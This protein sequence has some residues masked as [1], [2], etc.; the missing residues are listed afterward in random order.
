[1]ANFYIKWKGEI[2]GPFS[3]SEILEMLNTGKIGLLHEIREE[4]SESWQFLKDFDISKAENATQ[5]KS[6]ADMMYAAF[7]LG[8]ASFLHPIIYLF[9]ILFDGYIFFRARARKKTQPEWI[10]LAILITAVSGMAGI[11]F[12]KNI[13]PVLCGK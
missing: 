3:N 8:G 5:K 10:R 13:Y 9:A 6:D 4:N 12:Y 2:S 11:I 1:M 7:F